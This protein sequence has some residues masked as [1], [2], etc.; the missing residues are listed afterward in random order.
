MPDFIRLI[1]TLVSLSLTVSA[2]GQPGAFFAE[3]EVLDGWYHSNDRDTWIA[4]GA[5]AEVIDA[6]MVRI[7]DSTGER[8]HPDLVDT[9]IEYAP[10]NWA[11]EWVQA[12]D[13]ARQQAQALE[14]D[15]R[16][17]KLREALAYYTTGSWP[18][19]G[20]SDDVMAY[21]K[22]VA[23]Y[24]EA[25]QM[26]TVPV[27]H[28]QLTISDEQI[29]SYLH[30]P[31]GEGPFPLV[32]NS[33]GSDVSKEDSFELFH[34]ELEP[35]GIAMMAVDMP[36][37]GEARDLSMTEGSDAVMEAA[38]NWAQ[39]VE[40]IDND[41]VFIV[42]GSFG[43]NAAARAFYRLPVAGVVSMCGPLHSP[44]MA[45]PEFLDQLPLL[46]IEGVKSRFK[47][48]GQATSELTTLTPGTSLV[49]QGLMGAGNTVDT[50]LLVITTNRDPVAPLEDLEIF[51]ADASNAE[52][53]LLDMEG[54]CP[55]RTVREPIIARWVADQVLAQQ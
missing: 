30:L 3:D 42:G 2:A 38:L 28:I 11:Y 29:G 45:P 1:L 44:F 43:G 37:L 17:R 46:T 31:A 52:L 51:M 49:Q 40:L 6:V 41:K 8:H 18:H 14:G 16:L 35:R 9:L 23:V 13:R 5:D 53:V 7:A 55:P 26:M 15:A 24:L 50:P 19:L 10:G 20:R 32:I 21:E 25:G 47:M 39:G 36:G 34:R 33:F 12:G 48:L 22:A 27:Q 54:H 4:K